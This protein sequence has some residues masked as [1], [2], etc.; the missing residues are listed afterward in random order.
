VLLLVEAAVDEAGGAGE[1]AVVEHRESPGRHHFLDAVV[2]LF[3]ESRVVDRAEVDDVDGVAIA[4]RRLPRIPEHCFIQP[5]VYAKTGFD[6]RVE[7]WRKVASSSPTCTRKLA[8][9]SALN[10]G[11]RWLS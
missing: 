9:T 10:N 2:I 5:N 7:Q 1:Q 3:R 4:L 8:L 11:G 6:E